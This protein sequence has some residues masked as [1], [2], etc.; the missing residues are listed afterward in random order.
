MVLRGFIL[1]HKGK[2][3]RQYALWIYDVWTVHQDK[4]EVKKRPSPYEKQ[5]E[6]L[7]RPELDSRNCLETM[8]NKFQF[9]RK[10]GKNCILILTQAW[11]EIVWH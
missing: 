8:T 4:R 3:L 9:M 10:R 7:M 11:P 5:G 2:Q 6:Q 1:L